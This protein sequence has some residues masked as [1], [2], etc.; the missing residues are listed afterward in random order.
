MFYEKVQPKAR[1][2]E[3]RTQKVI[4]TKK[5]NNKYQM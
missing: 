2:K 3:F 1:K 5:L 4:K